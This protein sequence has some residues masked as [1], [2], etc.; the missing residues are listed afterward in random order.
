MNSKPKSHRT[1][2]VKTMALRTG[3][4]TYMLIALGLPAKL[5]TLRPQ[6]VLK[7]PFINVTCMLCNN[8]MLL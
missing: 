8:I 4:K 6:F 3:N 7:V 2:T 1:S 5:V